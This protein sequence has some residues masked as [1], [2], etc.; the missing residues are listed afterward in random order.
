MSLAYAGVI[1]V[2]IANLLKRLL[3]KYKQGEKREV[4]PGCFVEKKSFQ[5]IIKELTEKEVECFILDKK[6]ESIRTA[7]IPEN[8]AF[9]LGD[10][11]GIPKKELKYL[12]GYL[13]PVSI[14]PKVYFA[15]QT[16]AVVNNELD[17]RG[18]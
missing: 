13:T 3:Y 1:H 2:D 16:V 6:G 12:K 4:V 7:K 11:E 8:C 9:I 18:I 14:G 15:S 5:K 10:Q 17:F